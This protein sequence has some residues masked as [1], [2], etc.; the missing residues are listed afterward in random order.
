[1]KS[2]SICH[3]LFKKSSSSV[4][5]GKQ[6]SWHRLFYPPHM[7]LWAPLSLRS[8][9]FEVLRGGC[10][11]CSPRPSSSFF[12]S[13]PPPPFPLHVKTK[14]SFP[15]PLTPVYYHPTTILPAQQPV[16]VG[17]GGGE[18]PPSAEAVPHGPKTTVDW[19]PYPDAPKASK[20]LLPV[21]PQKT[22]SSGEELVTEEPL[23]QRLRSRLVFRVQQFGVVECEVVFGGFCR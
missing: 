9:I 3:S 21:L 2:S 8:S 13:A 7:L 11:F 18:V 15:Y 20:L 10:Y 22:A 19:S 23:L 17:G 16:T 14:R 4:Q 5:N 6:S 1:M 12:P